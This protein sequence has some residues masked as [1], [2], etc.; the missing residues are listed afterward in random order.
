[1]SMR[2]LL[3]PA[4]AVTTALILAGCPGPEI[5][6]IDPDPFAQSQASP[7]P[8]AMVE[9]RPDAD[10]APRA[11]LPAPSQQIP[12]DA[13]TLAEELQ[14]TTLALRDAIDSWRSHG[15]TSTYPPRD[16][17]QLLALY[18][19]R[20]YRVLGRDSRLATRTIARLPKRLRGEAR[21]NTSAAANLFSL[22]TPVSGSPG[23]TTADPLPAGRLLKHYRE[24]ES[25][26]GVAWEVL[27]AINSV[28]TRFNRITSSSTAG[29]QGPMQFI[30]STWAAY[31]MGGDIHDPRDAIIGAANY[32][33]ASGAPGDYRRALYAYNPSL[34]YVDAIWAYARQIM[35]DERDYFAYYNWQ[36]FVLTTSGDR[37]LTGP[38]LE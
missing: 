28:E 11:F 24:A 25:R 30:P 33:R 32:L 15:D 9:P 5:R 8:A 36:V 17:V 38:G 23:F 16:D 4:L 20:I 22:V 29:A 3:P 14:T 7:S 31:G 2:R 34:D 13:Q 10:V 21:A 12:R 26:F 19:Q 27:A 6:K 37:R 35:Q 18:Q 1:M